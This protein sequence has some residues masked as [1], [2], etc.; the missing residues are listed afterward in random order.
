MEACHDP[1]YVGTPAEIRAANEKRDAQQAKLVIDYLQQ[2]LGCTAVTVLLIETP[3]VG[4]EGVEGMA[5]FRRGLRSFTSTVPGTFF[6]SSDPNAM[7]GYGG[8]GG[9][10]GGT[11]TNDSGFFQLPGQPGPSYGMPSY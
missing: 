6:S 5:A 10:F 8:G 1:A 7:G 11:G 3:Q 4:Q 9:G 2:C